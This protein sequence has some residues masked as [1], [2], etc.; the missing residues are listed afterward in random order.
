MPQPTVCPAVLFLLFLSFIPIADA[1]E[2]PISISLDCYETCKGTGMNYSDDILFELTIRNNLDDWVKFDVSPDFDIAVSSDNLPYNGKEYATYSNLLGQSFFMKPKEEI[3]RYIPFDM[4][5]KIDADKRLGDWKI[6]P[7]LSLKRVTIHKNPLE[8]YGTSY[9]RGSYGDTFPIIG[10]VLE[11]K[12]VKPEPNIKAQEIENSNAAR[13]DSSEN[14]ILTT[15]INFINSNLVTT[16]IGGV[17]VSYI[18]YKFFTR[19]RRR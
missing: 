12:T 5:N 7:K 8:S 11:F 3:K 1:E 16:I 14:T 15:I 17:V 19:R 9:Y 18:T 6:Y 13:A 10:N 4:Y 2:E